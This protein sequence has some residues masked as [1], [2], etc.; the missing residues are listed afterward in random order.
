MAVN[1][2]DKGSSENGPNAHKKGNRTKSRRD[3]DKIAEAGKEYGEHVEAYK[4]LAEKRRKA[5]VY[6]QESA[7]HIYSRVKAYVEDRQA[8]EKP[9]TISGLILASGVSTDTYYKMSSG[10]YDYRLYE[11]MDLYSI[12]VEAISTY[13]DGM[14]VYIDIDMSTPFLY[15][16]H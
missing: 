16:F 7:I 8:Q 4:K 1:Q 9:L 14:P 6:K 3:A 13:I 12:D 2:W 11:Y 15:F 10:E 5:C